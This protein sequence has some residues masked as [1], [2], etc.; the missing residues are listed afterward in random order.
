MTLALGLFIDL[1]IDSAFSKL[2]IFQILAGIGIGPNFATPLI[3]LQSSI[4]PKDIA[5]ATAT[6]GFT[7]TLSNAISIVAGGVI[8]QN[9]LAR[10]GVDITGS[11][12]AFA[13]VGSI[14]SHQERTLYAMALQ[15]MWIL[16]IC[17]S[18]VGLALSFFIRKIKLSKN[19]TET[20]TRVQKEIKLARKTPI[21]NRIP[22]FERLANRWLRAG[23]I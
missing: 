7:R 11:E 20:M 4:K 15:R 17:T 16:Y 6:F 19:H 22:A 2:I 10:H 12:G 14:R 21:C 9:E 18:A 5:T 13:R 8:V 23:S 3:A 1:S